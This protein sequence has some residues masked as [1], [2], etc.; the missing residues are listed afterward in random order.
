MDRLKGEREILRLLEDDIVEAQETLK[1]GGP[2]AL[3]VIEEHLPGY[4]HRSYGLRF[5][6]SKQGVVGLV[7]YVSSSFLLTP[8]LEEA[9]AFLSALLTGS[10]AGYIEIASDDPPASWF[11]L[12]ETVK[13]L[14]AGPFSRI[15]DTRF[16]MVA[17]LPA[18][19]HIS[20]ALCGWSNRWCRFVVEYAEET[21]LTAETILVD[22]RGK[23]V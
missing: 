5:V 8:G 14:V 18:A 19:W 17:G 12:H 4:W 21:D 3:K 16:S 23:H 15:A 9:N 2:Q 7:G 10:A 13:G 6:G 1:D 20:P 11:M 22:L